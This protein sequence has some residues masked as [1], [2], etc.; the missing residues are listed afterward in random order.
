MTESYYYDVELPLSNLTILGAFF[1]DT[2][3]R[4][5][6]WTATEYDTSYTY[7]ANATTIRFAAKANLGT[8]RWLAFYK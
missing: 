6:N 2:D 8:V 3:T 5:L 7:G 4:A 1:T